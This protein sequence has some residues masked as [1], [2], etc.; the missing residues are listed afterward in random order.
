LH[1]VI[2]NQVF[3]FFSLLAN[4]YTFIYLFYFYSL[5]NHDSRFMKYINLFLCQEQNNYYYLFCLSVTSG[6]E[7]NHWGVKSHNWYSDQHWT[8]DNM[9]LKYLNDYNSIN[10]TWENQ[11]FTFYGGKWVWWWIRVNTSVNLY[12][13]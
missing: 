10:S 6:G 7:T 9:N 3:F 2:L 1:Y 5:L 11:I 4:S 12:I 13:T 8:T